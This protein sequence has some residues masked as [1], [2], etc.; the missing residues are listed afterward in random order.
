MRSLR[1]SAGQAA[2][3]WR[4]SASLVNSAVTSRNGLPST[5]STAVTVRGTSIPNTMAVV[6]GTAALNMSTALSMAMPFGGS[7]PSSA[8]MRR[9]SALQD[10]VGGGG[11][12]N[13]DEDG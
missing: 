3:Q 5:P 7:T 10:G 2:S 1:W 13:P 6:P 12:P 4:A 9:R 11:A 8:S